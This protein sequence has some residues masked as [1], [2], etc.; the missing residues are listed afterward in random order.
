MGLGFKD[1]VANDVLTAG[2]VDGYLMRQTTMVFA[3][4]AARD[5][6]LAG[7]LEQGMQAYTSDTGTHW[8]YGGSFWKVR[9]GSL[10]LDVAGTRTVTVAGGEVDAPI[11]TKTLDVEGMTN[12]GSA[13]IALG[14]DDGGLLM[15]AMRLTY[16]SGGSGSLR[17]IDA[18]GF[19]LLSRQSTATV[20]TSYESITAILGPSQVLKIRASASGSDATFSYQLRIVRMSY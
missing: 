15:I 14:P 19:S 17:V 6:A 13:D 10:I 1:F 9:E 4:A 2:Q 5:S 7:N 12:T 20:P 16:T 11:G 18:A 3:S 8:V